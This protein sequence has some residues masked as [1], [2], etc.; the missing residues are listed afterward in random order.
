[1]NFCFHTFL[2]LKMKSNSLN[3]VF[4]VLCSNLFLHI[5]FFFL[6]K[7]VKTFAL[8]KGVWKCRELKTVASFVII[9]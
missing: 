3:E 4:C 1:M 7:F 2:I 6:D 5:L 8:E 9:F